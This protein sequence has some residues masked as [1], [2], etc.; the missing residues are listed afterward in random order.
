[1]GTWRITIDGTGCHHNNNPAID[2]DLA[3]LEFVY[4]LKGQG[5]TISA[6]R[7]EQ[8][9]VYYPD[10]VDPTAKMNIDILKVI[11]EK[12]AASTAAG[13]EDKPKDA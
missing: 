13:G 2:A 7:F 9:G 5:H 6:A 8:R 3:V 4:H 11:T 12:E 1:M 10:Q